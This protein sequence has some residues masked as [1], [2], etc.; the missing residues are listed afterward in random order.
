MRWDPSASS[1]VVQQIPLGRVLDQ[2]LIRYQA[3]ITPRELVE[4]AQYLG[5]QITERQLSDFRQGK[6]IRTDTLELC[7]QALPLEIRQ[8][9]WLELLQQQPDL[10]RGVIWHLP[11]DQVLEMAAKRVTQERQLIELRSRS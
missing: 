4:R 10:L 9:Y 3:Q 1:S 8:A 2:V 6:G 5:A 11:T 7:L